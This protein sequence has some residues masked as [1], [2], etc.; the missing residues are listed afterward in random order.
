MRTL[1]IISYLSDPAA[2]N[3]NFHD[4]FDLGIRITFK[5]LVR[6]FDTVFSSKIREKSGFGCW[7]R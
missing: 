5:S 7:I 2:K 1:Q 3:L 4:F 6:E